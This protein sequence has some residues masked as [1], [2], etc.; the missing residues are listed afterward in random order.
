[1]LLRAVYTYSTRA[2]VHNIGA[3]LDTD[4][5]AGTRGRVINFQVELLAS[6]L[7]PQADSAKIRGEVE[8]A[9]KAEYCRGEREREVV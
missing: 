2:R 3:R 1:M 5:M 6:S 8:C 9:C 4:I 7:L